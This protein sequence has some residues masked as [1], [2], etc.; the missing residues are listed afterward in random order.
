M[1]VDIHTHR[2]SEAGGAC[3]VNVL[4]HLEIPLPDHSPLS[5]GVHP[6]FVP[7]STEMQAFL[8]Q[9]L[10]HLLVLPQIWALGELG[11][12][13]NSTVSEIDQEFMLKNQLLIAKKYQKPLIVHCVGRFERFLDIIKEV[14][15]DLPMLVHGFVK[16]A[17]LA[18]QLLR[19]PG[20]YLS[21][22]AAILQPSRFPHLAETLRQ[23]PLDRLFLETDDAP[24]SIS[25]EAIYAQ[26]ALIKNI[27][28]AQLIEQIEVNFRCFFGK[29]VVR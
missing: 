4:A 16:K 2:I 11:L 10:E 19:Q 17:D 1:Y 23:T 28:L 25:I 5:I 15:F 22:G 9:K 14:A 12:D 26:A 3:L 27:P 8:F 13:K 6:W 7:S 24:E 20:L 18:R 29:M 21:F